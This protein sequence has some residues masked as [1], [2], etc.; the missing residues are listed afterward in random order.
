MLTS[1]DPPLLKKKQSKLL[2]VIRIL[3]P[4]FFVCGMAFWLE[5]DNTTLL[6]L[7]RN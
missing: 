3:W 6:S 1:F 5:Q 7:A 2:V 4:D